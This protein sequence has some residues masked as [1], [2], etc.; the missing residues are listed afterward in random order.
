MEKGNKETILES[1]ELVATYGHLM[2]TIRRY[3]Y[4]THQWKYRYSKS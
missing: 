2:A 1:I 3:E 4:E